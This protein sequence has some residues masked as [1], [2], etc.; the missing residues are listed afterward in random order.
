MAALRDLAGSHRRTLAIAGTV[1]FAYA[2]GRAGCAVVGL[3]TGPAVPRLLRQV[4]V[5]L[6]FDSLDELTDA[7]GARRLDLHRI[8]LL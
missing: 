5:D 1:P 7:L 2:A 4:G 8:G 3:K 6:F